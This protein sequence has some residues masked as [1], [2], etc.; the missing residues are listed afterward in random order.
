MYRWNK[1][2]AF[3]I[4]FTVFLG[5]ICV[6]AVGTQKTVFMFWLLIVKELRAAMFSS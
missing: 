6:R 4:V 3:G 5:V 2:L 1:R